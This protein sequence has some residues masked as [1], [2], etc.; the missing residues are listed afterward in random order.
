MRQGNKYSS[1]TDG[2]TSGYG[3]ISRQLEGG[4]HLPRIS[5]FVKPIAQRCRS[6]TENIILEDLFS[7]ILSQIKKYHPS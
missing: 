6:K 1:D 3:S 7:S 2:I 4:C 5:P